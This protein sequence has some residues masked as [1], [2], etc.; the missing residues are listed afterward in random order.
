[1][2]TNIHSG[3][4]FASG[5]LHEI[6]PHIQQFRETL[7]PLTHKAIGSHIAKR[8]ARV[9][10]EAAAAEKPLGENVLSKIVG[11][12]RDEVDEIKKTQ[13]RNPSVDF[14]FKLS[15]MPYDGALYGMIYT[16]Q[17][18]WH[19]L[20][21]DHPW[22]NDFSFHDSTDDLPKGITR[23]DYDA[24]GRLWNKIMPEMVPAKSG[25]EADLTTTIYWPEWDWIEPE[26]E[27]FDTRVS[28]V[29]EN[30]ATF[31]RMKEIGS[32]KDDL[33]FS[34][35][36]EARRW[37][38]TDEGKAAVAACA[39]VARPLLPPVLSREVVDGSAFKTPK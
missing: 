36:W 39:D 12:F 24:R 27:D 19:K 29:A 38:K 2:S 16:E 18:A 17:Y 37:L 32:S 26:F 15:I 31:A 30:R 11:E 13:R 28:I 25:V 4:K 8:I 10:D 1:M 33:Y 14:E 9:I 6:W 22:V 5:D 7:V 23:R 34:A 3:I 20:F 35:F 21:M